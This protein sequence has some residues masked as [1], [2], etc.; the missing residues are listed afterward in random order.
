MAAVSFLEV[1]KYILEKEGMAMAIVAQ[2]V[3]LQ[4]LVRAHAWVV[5]WIPG[6]EPMRDNQSMF[7]SHTDIPLP[8]SLSSSLPLSLSR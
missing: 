6:G 8:L 2:L 4:F 1:M 7:I 5:G 3:G